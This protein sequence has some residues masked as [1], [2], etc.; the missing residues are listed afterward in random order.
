MKYILAIILSLF[1]TKSHAGWNDW[2]EDT[3]KLFVASSIA[4]SADYLLTR[5]FAKNKHMHPN[6]F[7][8]NPIIGRHPHHDKI[9]LMMIVMLVSNYYITDFIPPEQRNFYLS[10]RTFMHGTAAV[11]NYMVGFRIRF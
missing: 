2:N 9:D 11:N 1:L 5:D 8:M 3:K 6:A 10:V 7:E 4:I